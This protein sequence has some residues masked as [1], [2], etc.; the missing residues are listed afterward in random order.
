MY[1]FQS[2]QTNNQKRVN[3]IIKQST[4]QCN[5][6]AFF[7][8]YTSISPR[9]TQVGSLLPVPHRQQGRPHQR[10]VLA[11]CQRQPPCLARAPRWRSDSS[12]LN[13]L[14]L[15]KRAKITFNAMAL[16]EVRSKDTAVKENS[17]DKINHNPRTKSF[18]KWNQ[19]FR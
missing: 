7:S 13:E 5:F 11:C 18:L 14:I 4:K 6:I 2:M 17:L 10:S 1:V 12:A 15:Q 9:T 19:C 8:L 16:I 3:T